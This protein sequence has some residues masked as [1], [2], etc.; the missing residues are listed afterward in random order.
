MSVFIFGY[1]VSICWWHSI[2][3][4]SISQLLTLIRA[5]GFKGFCLAQTQRPLL[6]AITSAERI[7]ECMAIVANFPQHR[8]V[9]IFFRLIYVYCWSVDK[10]YVKR[11]KFHCCTFFCFLIGCSFLYWLYAAGRFLIVLGVVFVHI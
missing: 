11:L 5:C 10:N 9:Q 2:Y 6:F 7:S 1:D 8:A 3:S 4:V